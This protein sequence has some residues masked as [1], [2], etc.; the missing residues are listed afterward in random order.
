[1]RRPE[2][3][4]EILYMKQYTLMERKNFHRK[5]EREREIERERDRQ[6]HTQPHTHRE[7]RTL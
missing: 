7:L 5:R 2:C 3:V 1:M 4:S 6:T